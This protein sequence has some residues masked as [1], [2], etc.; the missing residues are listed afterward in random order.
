MSFSLYDKLLIKFYEKNEKAAELLCSYLRFENIMEYQTEVF[1]LYLFW[2]FFQKYL[3]KT[4]ALKLCSLRTSP[5]I[6]KKY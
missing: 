2:N 3:E 5:L 6:I 1:S 4:I